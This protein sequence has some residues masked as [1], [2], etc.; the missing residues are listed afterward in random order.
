MSGEP[1]QGFGSAAVW[2][3]RNSWGGNGKGEPQEEENGY[4]V[5]SKDEKLQFT[6]PI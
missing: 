6:K 3:A 1:G 2:G 4:H 5:K